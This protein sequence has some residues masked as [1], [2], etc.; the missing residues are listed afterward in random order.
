M[1]FTLTI[2]WYG[3]E[4]KPAGGDHHGML[5]E[6]RVE[7]LKESK[8]DDWSAADLQRLVTTGLG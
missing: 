8:L 7:H 3:N 5:C 6:P 2:G 1:P 4:G